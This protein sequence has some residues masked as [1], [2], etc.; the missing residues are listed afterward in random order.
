MKSSK[1]R[2][3]HRNYKNIHSRYPSQGGRGSLLAVKGVHQHDK[4]SEAKNKMKI[5]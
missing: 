4:K 2:E 3:S 1:I 5:L